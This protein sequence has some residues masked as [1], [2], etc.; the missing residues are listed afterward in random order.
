MIESRETRQRW[1]WLAAYSLTA[2]LAAPALSQIGDAAMEYAFPETMPLGIVLRCLLAVGLF[3]C[4]LGTMRPR[5]GHF[6]KGRWLRFPPLIMSVPIAGLFCAGI[7]LL[8]ESL[9]G[10]FGA[11]PS[12]D[13]WWATAA[14]CT[15][16]A[17][18]MVGWI[19]WPRLF[20]PASSTGRSKKIGDPLEVSIP[21]TEAS[22]IET[23]AAAVLEWASDEAPIAERSK[24]MLN[25]QE[26]AVRILDALNTKRTDRA[27]ADF[28]QTVVIQGAFGSGKSSVVKLVREEARRRGSDNLVFVTLNCWGFEVGTRVVEHVLTE[29]V[30]T[31]HEHVDCTAIRAAPSAYA[32][33]VA[34]NASGW[35]TSM[36]SGLQ[37]EESPAA[38]IARFGPLLATGDLH[39]VAIVEDTDRNGQGF[40][41][42][43]IEALLHQFREVERMAFIL[44]AGENSRIEFPKIA[45]H[46]EFLPAV[47]KERVLAVLDT[48]REAHRSSGEWI[49]PVSWGEAARQQE[50]NR[51]GSLQGEAQADDWSLRMFGSPYPNWPQVV[52]RLLETPRSLKLV[53]RSYALVWKKLRGEVDVDELL[54]VLVLRHA[55]PGAFSFL[56][57][58]L[59][60]LRSLGKGRNADKSEDNAQIQD[61]RADWKSTISAGR[62]HVDSVL[63]ILAELIPNAGTL[64]EVE[65]F[66]H[67]NRVQSLRNS[68]G[69]DYWERLTA[70]ALQENE[71]RDQV[72]L[73][74]MASL[75]TLNE[76]A[77]DLAKLMM[78]RPTAAALVGYF[79]EHSTM[80]VGHEERIQSALLQLIREECGN[81]ATDQ[82]TAYRELG[83]SVLKR[84]SHDDGRLMPWLEKEIGLCFPNNLRLACELSADH[85]RKNPEVRRWMVRFAQT[86]FEDQTGSTLNNAL[87]PT[88]PWT[89]YHMLFAFGE[90]PPDVMLT[91]GSDWA[92]MVPLIL[93]GMKAYP[94]VIGLAAGR[95]F[96]QSA[97]PGADLSRL[98]FRQADVSDYFGDRANEFY[99]SIAEIPAGI[100]ANAESSV[101]WE[102]ASSCAKVLAVR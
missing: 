61:L 43:Q 38:H 71:M 77:F 29:C 26:R 19:W 41:V 88:Y 28:C 54:M 81:R 86:H 56:G 16:S 24:D 7:A 91:R 11:P 102:R 55:A 94:A 25:S 18:G 32:R 73:S 6:L 5:R 93:E 42:G 27:S 30:D 49:D 100:F 14:G 74:A 79:A 53:A 2:S 97:H 70:E 48:I 63:T 33:A 22:T 36:L 20:S 50:R 10:I 78:R 82:V 84:F 12:K 52:A 57:R 34:A 75:A 13:L 62:F 1:A 64:L 60:R 69:P 8:P 83:W 44:S 87:D 65:N 21:S 92:F 31:L 76:A 67:G 89:L 46:I 85:G 40:D 45:E 39:L 58:N 98:H 51:V 99:A 72:V 47:R 37:S 23:R 90:G 68:E 101:F 35:I 59:S 66:N 3:A 4:V 96:F 15:V 95:C 80:A 17:S 9:L